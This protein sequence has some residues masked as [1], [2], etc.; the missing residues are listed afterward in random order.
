[1]KY[2]GIYTVT[3]M[4]QAQSKI[5]K[6]WFKHDIDL[7]NSLPQKLFKRWAIEVCNLIMMTIMRVIFGNFAK[8]HRPGDSINFGKISEHTIT[9]QSKLVRATAHDY[10]VY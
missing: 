3:R 4:I 6:F 2:I 10:L 8:L 1:M 5:L 7:E 9:M